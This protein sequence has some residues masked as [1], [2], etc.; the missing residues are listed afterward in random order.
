MVILME[1]NILDIE[2]KINYTFK[3]K[4]L[5]IQAFTRRSYTE[6]KG[7]YNN[8]LLEFIGDEVLDEVITNFLLNKYLTFTDNYLTSSKTE[9]DFTI[10]KSNLVSKYILAERINKLD[11]IKYIKIGKLDYINKALEGESIKE[12]LFE[13]IIGAISIDNNKDINVLTKVVIHMLDPEYYLKNGFLERQTNYIALISEYYQK[14]YKENLTFKITKNN[15][16][17]ENKQYT[18]LIDLKKVKFIDSGK[19]KKDAKYST[20]KK[21]YLWL[22]ERNMV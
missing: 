4:N 6:D 15:T 20:S 9:G 16:T 19:S 17:D 7:G 13:A 10:L 18:C 8:E 11:L 2:N 21:A 1:L 22:K 14:I 12:D 3:N 5:L